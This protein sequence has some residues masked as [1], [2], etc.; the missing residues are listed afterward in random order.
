[1]ANWNPW[2]GCR[3]LSEGCRNCYV[4][5]IDERHGRDASRVYKTGDFD[6]PL[7][8][9]RQGEYKLSPGDRV[10]TCFSSDFLLEEADPWRLE[11]WDMIRARPDL[12]FLFITKRIDRF[13]LC[14]PADWGEGWDN[15]EICCT[16]ENQDRADYRLP[17]FLRLPIKH[18]FIICEPLLGHIDLQDFLSDDI[19]QV[20]VGGESGTDAR[21]CRYEWVLDLREQCMRS[22]V[23][24]HFKQTGAKFIKDGKLYRIER[25]LQHE[26]AGKANIDYYPVLTPRDG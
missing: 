14:R 8:K 19:E 4:Y 9:N 24:F 15:V 26:Q 12:R 16:C 25:R 6:L 20:T 2:H 23:P 21:P 5:R 1:M 7:R 22:G 18:R 3:K 13:E 17:I 10:W 11:A